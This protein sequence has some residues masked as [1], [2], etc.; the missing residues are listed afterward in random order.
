MYCDVSQTPPIEVGIPLKPNDN[1]TI[2]GRDGKLENIFA[3]SDDGKRIF[4]NEP[5][6]RSISSEHG[7]VSVTLQ[8]GKRIVYYEAKKTTNGSYK[9][10][11]RVPLT[12]KETFG[13]EDY[14]RLGPRVF[15]SLSEEEIETIPPKQDKPTIQ[16]KPL[17][18]AR[19][20]IIKKDGRQTIEP[21]K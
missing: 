12:K 1:L 4:I 3:F 7:V 10:K 21:K 14:F 20:I 13:I 15:L 16:I 11:S 9:N 8:E 18:P 19:K 2:C 17:V 5:E 6:N